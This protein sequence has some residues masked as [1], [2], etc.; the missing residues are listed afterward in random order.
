VPF[1]EING[2][3]IAYEAEGDGAPVVHLCGSG[4]PAAVWDLQTVP[5]LLDAGFRTITFDNRG[6][7]PSSVPDPP[8]T[9][10]GMAK[11]TIGLIER[12][13]LEAVHLIGY[14]MGGLIAQTI[15]IERPDLV[16]SVVFL[17]GCGNISPA[18]IP[19]LEA[20]VELYT[21]DPL[22][23]A[24]LRC[25]ALDAVLPPLLWHDQQAVAQALE[26]TAGMTTGLARAGLIGQNTACLNWA[27]EDH[28]TELRGLGPPALAVASEWDRVFPPALVRQAAAT[29]PSGRYVQL[30]G[31]THVPA[32]HSANVAAEILRFLADLRLRI[33]RLPDVAT[34]RRAA[35]RP[36]RCP[37]AMWRRRRGSCC[38]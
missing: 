4:Q 15:A 22:P 12:M 30:A 16:L 14:S 6:T 29:M 18:A 17:Q 33:I 37:R 26:L 8:Y 7:P 31:A 5:T 28:L 32:G 25:L 9:V 3:R 10:A 38:R 21:I 27:R 1:A 35:G 24:S 13:D 19:Q 36:G 2:I 34:T 20:A 11:D 23:S